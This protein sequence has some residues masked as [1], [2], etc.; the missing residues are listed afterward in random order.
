[1]H[2]TQQEAEN[3]LR[4]G[5]NWKQIGLGAGTDSGRRMGLLP[6]GHLSCVVEY[7]TRQR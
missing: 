6:F 7:S 2:K 5:E 1:M 4:Q 3:F